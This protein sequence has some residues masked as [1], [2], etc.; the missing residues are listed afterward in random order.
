MHP[1]ALSMARMP[2]HVPVCIHI[3]MLSFLKAYSLKMGLYHASS[4]LY[5]V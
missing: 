5:Q 1:S 4:T 2:C 3:W